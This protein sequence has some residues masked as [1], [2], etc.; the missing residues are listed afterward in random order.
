M[1]FNKGAELDK[2]IYKEGE[3]TWGCKSGVLD[4]EDVKD[5][6][7]EVKRKAKLL[8]GLRGFLTSIDDMAGAYFYKK[9]SK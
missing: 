7:N 4:V 3:S 6:I 9:E 8:Y 1:K 5:F 2:Q